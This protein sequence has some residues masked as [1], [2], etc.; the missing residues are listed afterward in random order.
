MFERLPTKELPQLTRLVVDYEVGNVPAIYVVSIIIGISSPLRDCH[1]RWLSRNISHIANSVT[2][3][4]TYN[5][6]STSEVHVSFFV[7]EL[8]N[9]AHA[10]RL[11][12]IALER[13]ID[14]RS[15][16]PDLDGFLPGCNLLAPLR[17][18]AY[19][20]SLVHLS[21]LLG[22]HSGEVLAYRPGMC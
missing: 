5:L 10:F 11:V 14:L 19:E 17:A 3:E 16:L 4:F 2:D 8:W 7:D 18:Y 6:S 22:H 15:G 9:A 21:F 20:Y 13:R 12:N 1:A